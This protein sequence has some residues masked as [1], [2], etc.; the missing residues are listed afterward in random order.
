MSDQIR[1]NKWLSQLGIAS[2]REAEKWILEGR[3]SI[4]GVVAKDLGSK[5]DPEVDEILVDGDVI[6]SNLPPRVYWLL[7]KPDMYLSSTTSDGEKETI[8]DLPKLRKIPFKVN[9]VGR[10][11]YRTEGLLLLSNDGELVHRLMHPSYKIP[12]H[13]FALVNKKLTNQQFAELRKGINLEDGPVKVK[14]VPG[15][16]HKMGATTGTVYQVTVYEGRNRLVRRIFEHYDIKVVRLYR[17]G[18][19]EIRLEESLKPGDYRQLTSDEIKYL[20]NETGLGR[21]EK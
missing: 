16:G 10:L 6:R 17:Y 20:K 5:I 4:N 1:L 14:I 19:G 9:L 15:V 21:S 12:R 11:D 8:F 7:H 2:R 13:Y 18:I 3:I